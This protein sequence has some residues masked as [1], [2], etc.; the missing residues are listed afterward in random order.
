M[1]EEGFLILQHR[2]WMWGQEGAPELHSMDWIPLVS[3]HSLAIA[4]QPHQLGRF[5]YRKPLIPFYF[6][7]PNGGKD[8]VSA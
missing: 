4:L 5:S 3:A 7:F 2:G 6:H 1:L 8:A